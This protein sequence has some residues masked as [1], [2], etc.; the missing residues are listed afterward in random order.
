GRGRGGRRSLSFEN[1]PPCA[2]FR[3][4]VAHGGLMASVP[5]RLKPG[6]EHRLEEAAESEDVSASDMASEAIEAFLYAR[7][8]RRRDL[9]AAIAEA[10]KGIFVSSEAVERWMASWDTDHELPMPEPDIFPEN[11]SK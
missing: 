1:R 8:A 7:D 10:E 4:D 9:R 11:N 2:I 5:F 6:L 3:V